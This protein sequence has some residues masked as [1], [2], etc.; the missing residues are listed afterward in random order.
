MPVLGAHGVACG[1]NPP[2]QQQVNLALA[3]DDGDFIATA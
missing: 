1:G 3:L 2:A